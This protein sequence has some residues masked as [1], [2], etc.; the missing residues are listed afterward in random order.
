LVQERRLLGWTRDASEQ[1]LFEEIGLLGSLPSL[2]SDGGFSVAVTNGGASKIDAFLSR[3]TVVEVEPRSGGGRQLIG[4][5]R[6]TNGATADELPR[7]VNGN[8]VGLPVGTSRLL[9]S[10]YG[11]RVPEVVRLNGD[12]VEVDV[13][14]EG[15]WTVSSTFVNI[16]PGGSVEFDAVYHLDQGAVD[17]ASPTRFDQ[18]LAQ[19]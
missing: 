12:V 4:T 8:V 2:A 6:L 5:V 3:E 13:F 19:R 9:V 15:G 7:Y 10:L 1:A 14:S 18:P 11:P 16:P 17:S